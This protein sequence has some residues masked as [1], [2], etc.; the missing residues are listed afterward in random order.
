MDINKI[1]DKLTPIEQMELAYEILLRNA[2]ELIR[3][4]GELDKYRL[5][6]EL[7]PPI[8]RQML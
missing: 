8:L 1:L 4:Q 5:Q 3:L 7:M 6:K 2:D